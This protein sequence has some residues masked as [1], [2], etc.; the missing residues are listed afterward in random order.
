MDTDHESLRPLEAARRFDLDAAELLRLVHAGEVPA[1]FDRRHRHL[2]IPVAELE[3]YLD[4][5]RS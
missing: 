4:R 1:F 5:T 3:A 2:R